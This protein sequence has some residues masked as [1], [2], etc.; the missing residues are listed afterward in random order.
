MLQRYTTTH[1]HTHTRARTSTLTLGAK[2]V[3]TKRW[4]RIRNNIALEPTA[5]GDTDGGERRH[6]SA[7]RIAVDACVWQCANRASTHWWRLRLSAAMWP[8]TG[9]LS[10]SAAPRHSSSPSSTSAAWAVARTHIVLVG[11]E[12]VGG[13]TRVWGGRM[14]MGVGGWGYVDGRVSVWRPCVLVL[15]SWG[16]K[17]RRLCQVRDREG[18]ASVDV[19]EDENCDNSRTISAW[20]TRA[21]D[22]GDAQ[23]QY[24]RLW[25]RGSGFLGVKGWHPWRGGL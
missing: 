19:Y 8:D 25:G 7:I 23:P 4:D 22:G 9:K 17:K 5:G 15:C 24:I 13:R 1:H 2:T 16:V 14:S 18:G 3:H 21:T 20:A 11:W 6:M 12:Y 10:E